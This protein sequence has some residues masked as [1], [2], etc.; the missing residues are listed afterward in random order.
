MEE[1]TLYQVALTRTPGIG[2]AYTKKLVDH[3][4]SAKAIFQAEKKAL[5]QAKIPHETADRIASFHDWATLEKELTLLEKKG[6]RTLLSSD[7][8]Y[9]QRL[10]HLPDTPPLLYY[11]GKADLNTKKIIA[12]VGTRG[13]SDYGRQITDQLIRQLTQPDLLIISGL[14]YGIDACAHTAA[15]KNNIPTVA[16]LGHGLAHIYPRE[17]TRLAGDML[18]EGGLLTSFPLNTRP[19]PYRFP[20]RNNLVAGLCDAL[21]VIETGKKGGSLLTVENAHTHHKK[22]FAVPG[23][24]TDHRSA[25]CNS[26]IQQGRAELLLSGQQLQA[27]MGWEWPANHTGVQARLSFPDSTNGRTI[28]EQKPEEKILLKLLT[29]TKSLSLDELSTQSQLEI[30]AVAIHLL[31]LELQ[32][33]ISPQPGQ[34]YRLS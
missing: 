33:L 3:F 29:E 31:N 22:V 32:G 34:R 15:L 17:H 26:L 11:K 9:P 30:S 23:R 5:A 8:D 13:P 2:A 24:L 14:A 21:L 6:I 27:S 16:V 25:G 28:S 7:K 4:G 1:D 12:V 20:I 19:E 18:A 10:L